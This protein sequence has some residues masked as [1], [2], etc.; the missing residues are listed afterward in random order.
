MVHRAI[1]FKSAGLGLKL[2]TT[3]P[4]KLFVS[5]QLCLK[6]YL[7]ALPLAIPSFLCSLELFVCDICSTCR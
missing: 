5:S 3:K 6:K 2:A 1:N 7:T 4:H